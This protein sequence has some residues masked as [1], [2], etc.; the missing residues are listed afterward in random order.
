MSIQKKSLINT[1]KT[2]KKA[3]I[4]TSN[5]HEADA[6]GAKVA[7]MR[8]ASAKGLHAKSLKSMKVTSAKNV[9]AKG[10]KSLRQASVRIAA[11]HN[12]TLL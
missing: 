5:T 6:K 8:Y 7:S 9:T 12:Q 4:A 1:L 3:N 11:N 2:T 10:V